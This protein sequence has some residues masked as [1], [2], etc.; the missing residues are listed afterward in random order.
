MNGLNLDRHLEEKA[1]ELFAKN[2]MNAGQIYLETPHK[3]PFI[4]SWS[5]V[6]SAVP[7]IMEQL[8]TAVEK[9][10]EDFCA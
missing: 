10:H 6:K 9:D 3:S 4:P 5:R 8:K 2:I 7:D 1:V